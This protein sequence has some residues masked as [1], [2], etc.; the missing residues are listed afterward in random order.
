[1][2]PD[3]PITYPAV[4]GCTMCGHCLQGCPHPVGAPLD[5]KAKRSTNVSY[6][7]RAVATGNCEIVPNA[8]ATRILWEERPSNGTRHARATGVRW[9]DTGTG[10]EHHANAPV[11]VLAGGSIESPR[12]WLN[13]GLPNSNDAVGRRLTMHLQDFVTGFFDQEVNPHVGQ[14]TMARADFP[15]YGTMWSQGY[16]LQAFAVV[17]CGLGGGMW[18]D[19]VE[20]PW[21]VQGKVFGEEA[22]RRVREYS[23]TLTV[24]LSVNDESDPENRVTLATDWEPDEHGPIPRVTYHPTGATRQRQDWLAVKAAELLRSIGAREIHRTKPASAFM[25][26][27]MGTMRMGRDPRSSVVD[28]DGLSHEV[29]NLYVADTSVIP[30]VGGANPT[31][32]GQALATKTADAIADR[33]FS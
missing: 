29:E 27:L 19:P 28:D 33:W 17:L 18:S 9:R 1:M 24:V 22:F 10:E 25:T 11:V 13:S 21:D 8:F 14:V 31:L 23:R 30:S 12:L 7:P 5:R 32:T 6:V 16:G 20:G 15:G 3:G 2:S 26:H 4:D